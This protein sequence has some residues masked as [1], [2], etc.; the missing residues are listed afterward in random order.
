MGVSVTSAV[1][2]RRAGPYL[3]IVPER[4]KVELVVGAKAQK[5]VAIW[6]GNQPQDALP[7]SNHLDAYLMSMASFC[8]SSLEPLWLNSGQLPRHAGVYSRC[9]PWLTALEEG[10]EQAGIE[11]LAPVLRTEAHIV[12]VVRPAVDGPVLEDARGDGVCRAGRV[13]KCGIVV[14]VKVLLFRISAPHP[15]LPAQSGTRLS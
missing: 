3:Y 7:K 10:P 11:Y 5:M 15:S 13:T 12:A 8:I 4:S 2:C 6:R 9:L 1:L 14:I